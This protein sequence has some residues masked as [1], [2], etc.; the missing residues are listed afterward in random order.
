MSIEEAIRFFANNRDISKKI[1]PL[2]DVGL[3][4]VKM[5]QSSNTLSGGEAQR[6]KLASYLGKER[7]TE[8]ILFIFDEPSTR[9]TFP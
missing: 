1:Q 8:K 9:L 6:I 2:Y 3:G 4:Y 5:G 7:S